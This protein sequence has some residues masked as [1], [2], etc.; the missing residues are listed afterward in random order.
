[1][2]PG[3]CCSCWRCSSRL[4][5]A[6]A[7]TDLCMQRIR[8]LRKP[9]TGNVTSVTA[10]SRSQATS[11]SANP[12]TT[13]HLH[14]QD[15]WLQPESQQ[16][17]AGPTGSPAA[18]GPRTQPRRHWPRRPSPGQFSRGPFLSVT[19][20]PAIS[21]KGNPGS[22]VDTGSSLGGIVLTLGVPSVPYIGGRRYYSRRGVRSRPI[23]EH[24]AII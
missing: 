6:R 24:D 5:T 20:T 22:R 13:R 2:R 18:R 17:G 14:L 16:L 15:A 23:G 21:S 9:P 10:S 11:S 4:W 19:I 12:P 1:M 7:C 3:R 8:C